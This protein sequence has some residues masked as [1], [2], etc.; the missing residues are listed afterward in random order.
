MANEDVGSYSRRLGVVC[1]HQGVGVGGPRAPPL[2]TQ[3]SHPCPSQTE[4]AWPRRL[5]PSSLSCWRGR[6]RTRPNSI[7]PPCDRHLLNTYCDHRAQGGSFCP[8]L[9]CTRHDITSQTILTC[10]PQ[11]LRAHPL[12]I[13]TELGRSWTLSLLYHLMEEA[14]NTQISKP[15]ATY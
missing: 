7:L 5:S 13:K 15:I 11:P 9:A 14:D 10:P 12:I 4:R 3:L 6:V 2:R 8:F 1:L